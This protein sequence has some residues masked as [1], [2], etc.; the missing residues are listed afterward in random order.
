MDT[1]VAEFLD[2]LRFERRRSE[3]TVKSYDEDLGLFVDY[4]RQLD[5]S[6]SWIRILSVAGWKA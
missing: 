3:L 2:Y 4:V 6:L 5:E 1:L